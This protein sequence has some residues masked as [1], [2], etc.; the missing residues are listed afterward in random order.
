MNVCVY[1]CKCNCK[2]KY[3]EYSYRT[4]YVCIR[5]LETFFFVDC[6]THFS[7]TSQKQTNSLPIHYN[8]FEKCDYKRTI[9]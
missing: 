7:I 8:L 5:R 1:W 9:P 3:T 6:E 2:E 4:R